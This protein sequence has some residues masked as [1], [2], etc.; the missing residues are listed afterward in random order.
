MRPERIEYNNA[1]PV[2]VSI[3]YVEQYP[4]HWHDALEIIQV[5]EGSVNVSMGS[6]DL[7]LHEG[8]IAIANTDE[9]H[10]L[11]KTEQDNKVLLIHISPAFIK[12]VIPDD[13]FLFLYCCSVYHKD[14]APERY[15]E[16]KKY[17]TRLTETLETS[18]GMKKKQIIEA[19][20]EDMLGYIVY[21]FD[22]IRWGFGTTPLDDRRVERLRHMAER[23]SSAQDTGVGL[24]DMMSVIDVTVGHLSN[25][26]K[27]TFGLTFQELLH[28][29]KCAAAAKLLLST[30][31]RIV[32]IALNCGFSD[33]KYLIKHFKRFF[34]HTP[35]DFKR[36]YGADGNALVAQTRYTELP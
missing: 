28:Y 26:I 25:D 31:E 22:L 13:R 21:S 11:N 1:L 5:L 17:I 29:G 3:Q 14:Q 34:G 8:D 2:R 18:S 6:D 35:S 24:K 7:L 23:A 33:V 12:R 30:D 32:D 36:Q 15:D 9:I 19:L 27:D 16:L 20:L 10:R 4:Y